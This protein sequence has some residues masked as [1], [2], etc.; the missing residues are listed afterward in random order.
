MNNVIRTIIIDDESKGRSVLSEMIA[1]YCNGVEIVATAENG[2]EGIKAIK[3]YTPD[4]ILLDIQ[5]PRMDAFDMLDQLEDA[6]GEVVFVTAHNEYALKAF[7][8]AA[9][10]YLLKPVD[11]KDLQE[12]F[13]RLRK[14]IKYPDGNKRMHLLKSI[15]HQ[16]QTAPAKITISSAEGITIVTIAEIVY[17]QAEGP[18]TFFYLNTGEKLVA[19]VNLQ[20][21]E[22]LL[23]DHLFFRTHHSYLVNLNH[24]RKYN[25]PDNNILLSNGHTVDVSKRKKEEFLQ[26]LSEL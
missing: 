2:A 8:Y 6:H 26:I 12:V 24:I 10:D 19:S 5:M 17:L 4:C 25:K 11:P 16:P 9:F 21:Y 22:E 18:Y 20:K 13:D 3:H 7:K 14:R 23:G 1:R 15:M